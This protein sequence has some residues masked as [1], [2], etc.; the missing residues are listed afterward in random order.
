MIRR[1]PRS[2][3]FPYTTLF[4]SDTDMKPVLTK[5]AA[6]KPDLVYYPIFIAAGGFVTRQAKEVAG[7]QNVKLMS[8]DGTF[9]PD[10]YKA[11]GDAV[12]G[13][14][15]TSPDLTEAALGTRYTAFLP[16]NKK[17][18][19]ENVLSAFHAHAYDA[20]MIIFSAI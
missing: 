20:A 2:T 8:A 10:F 19:G 15:H 11:G 13:M 3:L 18:Y 16:K 17:K 5:I 4:R 9:S 12:V 6:G 14:Y 7:L 1:P